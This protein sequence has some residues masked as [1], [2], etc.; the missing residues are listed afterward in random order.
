MPPIASRVPWGV[1]LGL[2]VSATALAQD[3]H[4]TTRQFGNRAWLLGGSFV[5]NPKDISAVYYNPGALALLGAPELE[6]TG[7]VFEYVRLNVKNG[8]GE[9]RGLADSNFDV[10]PSLLAG[11]L[12][13]G[14]LGRS[15][16]AYSLLT[17][18]GFSYNLQARGTRTGTDLAGVQGLDLLSTDVRL[19]QSVTEVWTGLSWALP[20]TEHLGLGV[21]PF[22]AIRHHQLN[23]QTLAEGSG[24]AG[25]RLLATLGRDLELNHVRL[26]LKV[27]AS[28]QHGPW[29]L[30]GT[31]TTPSLAV[32]GRGSVGFERAVQSQG[33]D[34]N[35][36]A[37][38]FNFQE[39][40]PVHFRNSWSA[41]LGASRSFGPST[42]VYAS[43]EGYA[44][45][46]SLTLVATAPIVPRGSTESINGDYA[47]ALKAVLNGA[48]GVEQ[49]LGD[50]VRVYLSGHTD[51]S[52]LAGTPETN[53]LLGGWDLFHVASGIHFLVGRSRFTLGG[54]VAWGSKQTE[55]L[56][57]SLQQLGLSAPARTYDVHYLQAT[58]LLG[59][60]FSFADTR[61]SSG[62]C[63]EPAATTESP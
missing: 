14:F 43:A 60:S 63:E 2:L 56:S 55:Q 44:R 9:G 54:N 7:T 29:A 47:F 16:L 6:L 33:L 37:P 21:S 41:A 23:F 51:F 13:F 22:V 19:N 57:D 17:R 28:Y 20:V 26:L 45:V 5:G 59:A 50:R 39:G 24:V 31:V 52:A 27:G 53:A 35:A 48:L 1:V 62:S 40:L 34:T 32:W 49:K 25:Q 61:T 15:R 36:P 42:T 11:S 18:Q 3:A 38:V 10:L 12:R 4:Y 58:L 8:L 30:G 46:A